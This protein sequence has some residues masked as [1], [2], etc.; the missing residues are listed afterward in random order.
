M[1][2]LV[3]NFLSGS[4]GKMTS[5]NNLQIKSPALSCVFVVFL[6]AEEKVHHKH[7]TCLYSSGY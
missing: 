7:C 1:R 4:C 6:Q 2:R 3:K 5:I